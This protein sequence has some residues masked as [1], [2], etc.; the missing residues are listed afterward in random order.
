MERTTFKKCSHLHRK[1]KLFLGW[2]FPFISST[3]MQR[4]TQLSAL[5]KTEKQNDMIE[6]IHDAISA[7]HSKSSGCSDSFPCL[8]VYFLCYFHR[9]KLPALRSSHTSGEDTMPGVTVKSTS[10]KQ[11]NQGNLSS[12]DLVQNALVSPYMKQ[13]FFPFHY[14]SLYH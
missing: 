7:K 6:Y 1:S 14:T 8:K 10:N 11:R 3:I 5:I 13:V 9:K 12:S 2:F 4:T